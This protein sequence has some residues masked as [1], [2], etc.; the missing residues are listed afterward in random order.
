MDREES[1]FK[2]SL[3]GAIEELSKGVHNKL[4]SMDQEAI[5]HPKSFLMDREAIENAIKRS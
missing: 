3:D 5:E 2:F 1:S 4:T